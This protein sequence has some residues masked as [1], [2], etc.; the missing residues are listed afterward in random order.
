MKSRTSRVHTSKSRLAARRR[1]DRIRTLVNTLS[2]HVDVQTVRSLIADVPVGPTFRTA[3]AFL[4]YGEVAEAELEAAL[5]EHEADTEVHQ[6]LTSI[7]RR[8]ARLQRL[9]RSE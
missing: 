3:R 4:R 8:V 1:C 9:R 2:L 6:R 7:L 5:L